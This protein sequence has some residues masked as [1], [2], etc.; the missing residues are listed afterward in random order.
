[1]KKAVL[2]LLKQRNITVKKIAELVYILQE[3]YYPHLRLEQC[4]EAVDTV[5]TKRDV[6]H[7]IL[8]GL[9]LDMAA[10]KGE[11]AEPLQMI[12]SNDESLY[13]VDEVLGMAIT[14]I[15]GT[16]GVTGFGY[17]DKMKI[18]MTLYARCA[19]STASAALSRRPSPMSSMAPRSHREAICGSSGSLSSTLRSYFAATSSM[20]LSP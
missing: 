17:L 12:I 11:L 19:A 5:L 4:L 7:A 16:I 18:S 1:M 14:N 13:G 3:S 15:Y 2:E 20:W 8:T 10:E 6:Q 9:A